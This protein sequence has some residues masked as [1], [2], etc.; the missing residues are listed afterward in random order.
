MESFCENLYS[1]RLP[2][3]TVGCGDDIFVVDQ[4]GPA[5]EAAK[6]REARHPGVFIDGRLLSTHNSTSLVLFAARCNFNLVS[7]KESS[8]KVTAPPHAPLYVCFDQWF[9]HAGHALARIP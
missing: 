1:V 2:P 5:V 3:D 7:D 4:G 8:K 9:E 6:V